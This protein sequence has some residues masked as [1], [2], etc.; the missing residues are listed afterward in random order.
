VQLLAGVADA[1]EVRHRLDAQL[2][3]DALH[4]V[5][6]EC[7]GPAA[8][9]VG[10]RH[11]GGLEVAQRLDCLEQVLL[12][13]RG[14]GREELERKARLLRLDDLVDAHVAKW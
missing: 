8:R 12:A 3:L 5:D 14:P 2:V 11:V 13:L 1:G 4:D 7:A 9:A 10:D 6:R